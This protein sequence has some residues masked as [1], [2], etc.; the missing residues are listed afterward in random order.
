MAGLEA[1]LERGEVEKIEIKPQVHEWQFST[2][3]MARMVVVTPSLSWQRVDWST[4]VAQL[5]THH[6]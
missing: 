6:W 5:V 3:H 2:P 4:L 1:M